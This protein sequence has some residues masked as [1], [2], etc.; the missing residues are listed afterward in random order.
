M[1]KTRDSIVKHAIERGLCQ[2]WG[3]QENT[4]D[5]EIS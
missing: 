4:K 5:W 1:T 3:K 2:L